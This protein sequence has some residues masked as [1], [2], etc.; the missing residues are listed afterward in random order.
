VHAASARNE[1]DQLADE[2]APEPADCNAA[3]HRPQQVHTGPAHEERAGVAQPQQPEPEEHERERGAVVHPGFCGQPEAHVVAI[4]ETLDLHVGCE[5]GVGRRE[6]RAEKDRGAQWQSEHEDADRHD[7]GDRPEHRQRRQAHCDA[8]H[9]IGEGQ[10]ELQPEREQGDQHRDLEDPLQQLAVL[11]GLENEQAEPGRSERE[12]D[13]QIQQARAQGQR[14][15]TEPSRPMRISSRPT[16]MNQRVSTRRSVVR[17]GRRR[18]KQATC[19]SACASA[20]A[21]C[22]FGS[23]RRAGRRRQ[24]RARSEE[25]RREARLTLAWSPLLDYDGP[26]VQI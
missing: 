1:H 11:D 6:D 22:P 19:G 20:R 9:R 3:G 2:E 14:S 4:V 16:M 5:H 24:R 13:R 8:P 25:R 26:R 18:T 10:A 15:T 23:R 12:A 21:A 17:R 7:A